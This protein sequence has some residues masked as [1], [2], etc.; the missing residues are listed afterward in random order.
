MR[1]R[2]VIIS[3][4]VTLLMS[5]AAAQAQEATERFI[6]VGQSPGLS[7]HYTYMGTIERVDTASQTVTVSGPQGQRTIAITQNTK[8]WLDRS[9]LKQTALTGTIADLRE[10]TIVEVKYTDYQTKDRAAWIKVALGRD[11]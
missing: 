6:P 2:S 11:D 7:S 8:I 4:V 9:A 3:A 10:G 1:T 5:A